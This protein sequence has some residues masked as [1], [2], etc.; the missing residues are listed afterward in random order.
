MP[1]SI[2]IKLGSNSPITFEGWIEESFGKYVGKG[3]AFAK[4]K[5]EIGPGVVVTNGP[6]FL[7][8]HESLSVGSHVAPD[9]VLA[10]GAANGEDIPY[11]QP[12]CIF[13][14]SHK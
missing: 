3:T 9:E 14:P 2:T 7:S 8:S 1:F 4:G 11:G 6:M 10:Y 13:V 5:G 12:Y